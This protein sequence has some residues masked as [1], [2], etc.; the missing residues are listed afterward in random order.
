MRPIKRLGI[1][2]VRPSSS[3]PEVRGGAA[4]AASR[5]AP[6]K[7]GGNTSVPD[8]PL[9]RTLSTGRGAYFFDRVRR[10]GVRNQSNGEKR[11]RFRVAPEVFASAP[12]FVVGVVVATG[13]D[14]TSAGQSGQARD[15]AIAADLAEASAAA[16]VGRSLTD[17]PADPSVAVWR[18]ALAGAGIDPKAYPS[19]IESLLSRVLN[20]ESVPSINPAVDIANA[21]S[22]R[23]RVPIG[24]HN[25]DRLRGELV[26]RASREGDVFTP[27]NQRDAESVPPGEIVYAD[28]LEVRTR[29]WIW[30]LGEHGKVTAGTRNV[31]FPI[32]GFVGATAEQVR[33]ATAE[34]AS[35]LATRLG[36]KTSIGFVDFQH[37]EFELPGWTPAPVDPIESLLTRRVVEV[38]PSRE[39]MEKVLRS[40]KKLRIYLGVDATSPVIHVGHA[41]QIQ[42]LREFQDLGH[43]VVLLIGDFTGRIGDPTDKSAARAQLTKEQADENA[44]TYIEQAGKILDFDS[45]DNPIEVRFNGEWWDR[46]TSKDLI[47][48]A[49]YFT[50][51]Q[52]MQRDMFQKRLAENKPIGLHEFLYPLLQGYDS[53]ALNVD[54]ELGGTD[55]TF[56][57]LAGRTL[58]KGMQDK[59]KFVL[60]GPLLEGLDG[61]KMSKSYGN[62]IGVS[63]PAYDIY[64]KVMSLKDELI[65][66]YF[67]MV[68]SVPEAEIDQMTRNLAT[69][70]VNPMDLKKRLATDLV[71][72][73]H[74]A[75]EAAEAAERFVRE[76]QHHEVPADIPSVTLERA[77]DW[78]LIDLLVACKLASGRNDAKRLIEGGSVE[79]NGQKLTDVRAVV[80][81]ADGAV[82]RGRRRQYVRLAVGQ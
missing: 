62:V 14:N 5:N 16:R 63:E 67:E 52:M 32:D 35:E 44:R 33:A 82:L 18:E 30:R 59:E 61:R 70:A 29:R 75:T 4:K 41:V 40:G 53:V 76:V 25:L 22:L 34:L 28:D 6:A 71:T 9:V 26:V 3:K 78:P 24:A 12:S 47:E 57:M 73:F 60:T 64:G 81:V 13:F 50:V 45:P 27:R 56:N 49:A 20:G 66:R 38:L 48:F 72:R 7:Y 21:V 23:E 74:N 1:V 46:K 58:V 42:K 55:Q 11:V 51:Q 8:R 77:G 39:E 19:S 36:A 17:L 10:L 65:P 37:P 15:E 79:L 69:G 68:S 43:K 2:L 80:P 31:I 54:A